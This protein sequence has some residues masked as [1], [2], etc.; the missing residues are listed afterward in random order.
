MSGPQKLADHLEGYISDRGN[1]VDRLN[2]PFVQIMQDYINRS[3][4]TS[5]FSGCFGSC[6]VDVPA[7]GL[8]WECS[9]TSS[10]IN[11]EENLPGPEGGQIPTA[12]YQLYPAFSVSFGLESD[13]VHPSMV[14]MTVEYANTTSCSGELVTKACNLTSAVLLYHVALADNVVTLMPPLTNLIVLAEANNTLVAEGYQTFSTLGGIYLAAFDLFTANVTLNFIGSGG[15][16]ANNLTTF[17]SAYAGSGSA[18]NSTCQFDWT[19]PTDDIIASLENIMFR[20]ALQIPI[21]LPN[22][23]NP[24]GPTGTMDTTSFPTKQTLQGIDIGAQNFFKTQYAFMGAAAGVITLAVLTVLPLYYN[25]WQL[26]RAVSFSPIETAKAFNSPLLRDSDIT[27]RN[28]E[29]DGLV[30]SIGKKRVRYGFVNAE[31]NGDSYIPQGYR[32]HGEGD[33]L[34]VSDE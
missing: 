3:P 16:Q 6:S 21:E 28:G 15:Y 13:G 27:S 1:G 31:G 18:A 32:S 24:Y 14:E 11:Y 33:L 17:A 20:A 19:D 12:A 7:A 26:G 4:L 30:K 10:P 8:A 2:A 25:F 5:G 9:A 34:M 22:N 29:V 23:T